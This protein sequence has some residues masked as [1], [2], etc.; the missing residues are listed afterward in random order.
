MG[1]NLCCL[2]D[3]LYLNAK[4]VSLH[5][6]ERKSTTEFLML[7]CL[8]FYIRN[9][10]I[11]QVRQNFEI[12]ERNRKHIIKTLNKGINYVRHLENVSN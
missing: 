7:K 9:F 6:V 2:G 3:Q 5:S 12:T 11:W 8:Q 10:N 4:S 1:G